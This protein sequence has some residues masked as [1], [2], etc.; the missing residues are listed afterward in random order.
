MH[1]T[2]QHLFRYKAWANDELLTSLAR[3]GDDSPITGL[4]IKALSHSYIVDR[5]FAAHMRREA[6]AYT[7]A[8]S[9]EMPTLEH[10]SADIR[11]SDREYID[12]VSTLDRDQLA[13]RIDFTFTDGVPGRMSREE[14]LMHV[15][16]HGTGHRGQVSAV[17]LLNSLSPAK[18]GFT[19]FLHEA[20]ASTRRR[21][22][23]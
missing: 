5:I 4:A 20:E 22:A 11:N 2:L 9:I 6:H 15:I 17:M 19:T 10:L 21:V 1:D 7:S 16:T 18:D 12:Y 14:M 13:D 23:A 8:N 3:L